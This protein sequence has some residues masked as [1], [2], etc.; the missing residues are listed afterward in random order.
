MKKK[1]WPKI[2]E[3]Y[4]DLDDSDVDEEIE[5][6]ISDID[7]EF[8]PTDID[9]ETHEELDNEFEPHDE[10][11]MDDSLDQNDFEPFDPGDKDSLGQ[12]QNN[13]N[14]K[15][16]TQVNETPDYKI[17]PPDKDP[18]DNPPKDKGTTIINVTQQPEKKS[19][20]EKQPK[21]S[22][23]KGDFWEKL[24]QGIADFIK[25]FKNFFVK[26]DEE[27]NRELMK[28]QYKKSIYEK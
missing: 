9:D 28:K 2:S 11:E 27:I 14:D 4:E 24:E 22:K 19:S 16:N 8:E 25:G 12:E 15:P 10:R 23:P 13:E 3:E 1:R 5:D 6:E 18:P 21:P 7:E 26:S 17:S 20:P